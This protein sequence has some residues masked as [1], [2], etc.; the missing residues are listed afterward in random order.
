MVRVG[1]AMLV[2][3]VVLTGCQTSQMNS[4]LQIMQVATAVADVASNTT[5]TNRTP[6]SRS[7]AR[8]STAPGSSGPDVGDA[9]GV[10][11]A[12]ASVASGVYGATTS[13]PNATTG[14]ALH[15]ASLVLGAGATAAQ[16][17]SS[18]PGVAN[19]TFR[20]PTLE[21][22]AEIQSGRQ[23]PTL[24]TGLPAP[25]TLRSC[26]P[27]DLRVQ[28]LNVQNA[29]SAM[30][31]GAGQRRIHEIAAYV[32]GEEA[33]LYRQ[34]LQRCDNIPDRPAMVASV[35]QLEAAKRQSQDGVRQLSN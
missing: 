11:S 31:V 27:N 23:D 13:S 26:A 33:S 2:C 12:L 1:A 28:I 6:R 10:G 24:A 25:Q 18:Q 8:S 34:A 29:G 5:S 14:Q 17:V 32:F 4:A 30:S 20:A 21:R 7:T 35:R 3:S 22:A 19:G 15:V 16:P 9:L